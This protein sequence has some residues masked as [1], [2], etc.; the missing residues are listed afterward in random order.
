MTE[1]WAR[2]LEWAVATQSPPSQRRSQRF[3]ATIARLR[4]MS[5]QMNKTALRVTRRWWVLLSVCGALGCDRAADF[6][7]YIGGHARS[8]PSGSASSTST[9]T[10][11]PEALPRPVAATTPTLVS[12]TPTYP[13]ASAASVP[14][15]P[16]GVA[17]GSS[18]RNRGAATPP[19]A[20]EPV[21]HTE[22]P[23]TKEA[24][25]SAK[26]SETP[27][28]SN[29]KAGVVRN[30]SVGGAS[31]FGG[32]VSNAARVIAGLR[33]AIRSCYASDPT[34]ADGGLRL[35]LVL[36]SSG[37]VTSV[38]TTRSAGTHGGP[39][40]SDRVVACTASVAQ[41][42]Q[43]APPENGTAEI[44]LPITFS[45]HEAMPPKRTTL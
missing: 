35:K 12:A 44:A 19:A 28:P 29:Q 33:P 7:A 10:I 13:V 41:R 20:S 40:P 24:V 9:A 16:V 11:Q 6:G 17:A 45:E 31:V 30:A 18:S 32:N 26:P 42:A 2:R 34:S 8:T 39:G 4:P 3:H 25:A 23:T 43:F 21:A 38:S 5:N 37:A 36:S 14:A 22:P 1:E 27:S 15:V